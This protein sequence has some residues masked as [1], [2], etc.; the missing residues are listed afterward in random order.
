MAIAILEISTPAEG[1]SGVKNDGTPWGPIYTQKAFV[2]GEPGPYPKPID[3]N[4]QNETAAYA[5]GLYVVDASALYMDRQQRMTIYLGRQGR[6]VPLEQAQDQ[7]K[8]FIA[9]RQQS[10]AA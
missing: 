5:P 2:H 8:A 4:V 10:K 6:L 9:S 3:F 1:R 7:I